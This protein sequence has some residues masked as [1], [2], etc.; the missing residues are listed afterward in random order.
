LVL[1]PNGPN[2]DLGAIREDFLGRVV[3]QIDHRSVLFR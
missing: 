1:R 2:C 3:S